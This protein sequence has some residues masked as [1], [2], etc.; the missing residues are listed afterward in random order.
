MPSSVSFFSHSNLKHSSTQGSF[1]SSKKVSPNHTCLHSLSVLN[2]P[3]PA[4][5][6][7]LCFHPCELMSSTLS[8]RLSLPRSLL[9]DD[10]LPGAQTNL[11]ELGRTKALSANTGC[12]QKGLVFRETQLGCHLER[13]SGVGSACGDTSGQIPAPPSGT[14]PW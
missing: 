6:A 13:L 10:L 12:I 11:G 9:A 1:Y 3:S 5:K 14:T 8:G 7:S 4:L 2:E